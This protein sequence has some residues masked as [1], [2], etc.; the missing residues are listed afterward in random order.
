MGK[1]KKEHAAPAEATRVIVGSPEQERSKKKRKEEKQAQWEGDKNKEK[2]PQ[3]RQQNTARSTEQAKPA[4]TR[5]AQT[6]DA[7]QAAKKAK[8][9][10]GG[11]DGQAG[12]ASR[13]GHE[14]AAHDAPAGVHVGSR[15]PRKKGR[16]TWVLSMGGGTGSGENCEQ[17]QTAGCM[18]CV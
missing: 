3:S 4:G 17:L 5:N 1:R 16:K 2:Q 6:D 9:D 11:S 13:K 8:K 15:E 7:K 14:A 10:G 12:D 18:G